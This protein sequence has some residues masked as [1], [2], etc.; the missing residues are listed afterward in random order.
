MAGTKKVIAAY[1]SYLNA[2]R[3]LPAEITDHHRKEA[4]RRENLLISAM[5]N[6]LGYRGMTADQIE[7]Y[8]SKGLADRENLMEGAMISLIRMSAL[9]ER[10]AIAAEAIVARLPPEEP[11]K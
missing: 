11:Q 6:A 8:T 7:L 4:T 10:S 9:A 1:E 3:N 2:V 5:L